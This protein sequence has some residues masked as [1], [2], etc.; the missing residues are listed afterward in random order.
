M[1]IQ[2]K[3]KSSNFSY[4]IFCSLVAIFFC[5]N[6]HSKLV[7][8]ATI[9]NS[10]LSEFQRVSTRYHRLQVAKNLEFNSRILP[11]KAHAQA[12]NKIIESESNFRTGGLIYLTPKEKLADQIL[13]GMK[14]KAIKRGIEEPLSYAPSL[15][16][17]HA[18]PLIEKDP[19]FH[20][21][22]RLPKG[23]NLHIHNSASVSSEWV[24][25]NLTY[26]DDVSVCSSKKGLRIFVTNRWIPSIRFR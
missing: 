17:F 21:L 19:I 23:G 6:L 14:N 24:I 1:R 12:R 25:K 3:L 13:M 5:L 18:K 11:I 26:R 22:K 9:F 20:V 15:H 7:F 8:C 2:R 4:S 10:S 16:F